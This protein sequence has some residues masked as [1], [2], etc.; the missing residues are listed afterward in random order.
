MSLFSFFKSSKQ[1]INEPKDS[2]SVNDST[3]SKINPIELNLPKWVNFQK[4]NFG[5]REEDLSRVIKKEANKQDTESHFGISGTIIDSMIKH[6]PPM[7]LHAYWGGSKG[8]MPNRRQKRWDKLMNGIN[9]Q[10]GNK[11]LLRFAIN[12]ID[13]V[14][15]P[16]NVPV[17]AL[18]SFGN[19]SSYINKSKEAFELCRTWA[20][21]NN[22]DAFKLVAHKLSSLD[23]PFG[24]GYRFED[25]D[26]I[27]VAFSI[28]LEDE[29]LL[30]SK[31]IWKN[32][33]KLSNLVM[34]C[35]PDV[36]REYSPSW[37][38]GQRLDIF[39]PSIKVGIEYQGI[40]HYEPVNFFGGEKGFIKTQ[41]RDN[42]KKVLCAKNG[43]TLIEWSYTTD[44]NFKN[45]KT[46]LKKKKIHLKSI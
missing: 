29:S 19:F 41:E 40:Q 33:S 32:E 31:S 14:P 1:V 16:Y 18:A 11:F 37:L 39:I 35:F 3:D 26:F 17:W 24:V 28:A 10:H 15:H 21:E 20:K 36:I 44:I 4:S 34:S 42:R 8:F 46:E 27:D 12:A 23:I 6:S 9:F 7:F 30:N 22:D 43:I 5:Q 25:F 45:L 38:R 2:S 13:W